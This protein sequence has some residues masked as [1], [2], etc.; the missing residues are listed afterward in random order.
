VLTID[1]LKL[2]QFYI[3]VLFEAKEINYNYTD[4][5]QLQITPSDIVIATTQN[6]KVGTKY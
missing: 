4:S 2:F 6:E 5:L 1:N 3:K